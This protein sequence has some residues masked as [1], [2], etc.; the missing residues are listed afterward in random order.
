MKVKL[1]VR[2]LKVMGALEC[3]CCDALDWKE[4]K[5]DRQA[6]K[7]AANDSDYTMNKRFTRN[8]DHTDAR[9]A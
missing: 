4:L 5:L 6:L 7:E 9:R 1:P 3:R 8:V 2:P